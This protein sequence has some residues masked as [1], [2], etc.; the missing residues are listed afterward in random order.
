MLKVIK[1]GIR[2]LEILEFRKPVQSWFVYYDIVLKYMFTIL[3]RIFA[4]QSDQAGPALGINQAW[5]AKG[6]IAYRSLA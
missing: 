3:D 2:N 6:T 1:L 5:A 4:S